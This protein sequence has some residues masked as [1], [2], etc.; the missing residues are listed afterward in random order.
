MRATV[1]QVN[2]LFEEGLGS[3]PLGEA[4]VGSWLKRNLED[5]EFGLCRVMNKLNRPV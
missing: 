5:V 4:G 3:S 1:F 2:G